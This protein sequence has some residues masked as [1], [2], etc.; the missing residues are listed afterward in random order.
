MSQPVDAT[1]ALAH[2]SKCSCCMP[3]SS[4]NCKKSFRISCHQIEPV[5]FGDP[6]AMSEPAMPT[7]LQPSCRAT[8]T[9]WLQ[10]AIFT[11]SFLGVPSTFAQST[12]PGSSL[13]I[14]FRSTTPV[15]ESL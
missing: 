7:S 4:M 3:S 13:S 12:Q 14:T 5:N 10:F 11:K 6:A 15:H 2:A 9:A 8:S 1:W